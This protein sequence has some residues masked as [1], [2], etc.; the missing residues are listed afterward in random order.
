MDCPKCGFYMKMKLTR[1]DYPGLNVLRWCRLRRFVSN[2]FEWARFQIVYKLD[3]NPNYCWNNLV[4]W[5]LGFR[6]FRSLF[7][8]NDSENDYKKQECRPENDGYPYPY[9]GKCWEYYS[10]L[11]KRL[12]NGKPP[13]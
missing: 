3:K 4:Q 5:A 11:E 7:F 1:I 8:K 6:R 2:L 9:C 10:E 12:D 13:F